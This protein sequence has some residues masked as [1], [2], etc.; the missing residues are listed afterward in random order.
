M[1][2]IVQ[3]TSKA[4]TGSNVT[5]SLTNP[6]TDG[7]TV[8]IFVHLATAAPD[9]TPAGWTE[10]G[11]ATAGGSTLT[12]YAKTVT[13]TGDGTF[14]LTFSTSS[15]YQAGFCEYAGLVEGPSVLNVQPS[16]TAS[17]STQASGAVTVSNIG[18]VLV[19][20]TANATVAYTGGWAGATEIG[21]PI[22]GDLATWASTF[23][24][25]TGSYN[26]TATL[27]AS[28]A[29]EPLGL[30][31]VLDAP[32][33]AATSVSTA[34]ATPATV[35]ISKATS[36]SASTATGAPTV[37]VLGE[38]TG[39]ADSASV[40]FAFPNLILETSAAA[41]SASSAVGSP[42]NPGEQLPPPPE[43]T[44]ADI[45]LQLY[46]ALG[47]IPGL[48]VGD[49]YLG[50]P[51]LCFLDGIGQIIQRIAD[52]A[53]DTAGGPGWSSLLDPTRCPPY[54]LAWLAQCVGVTFNQTQST[55]AAQ[56]AA[57]QAEQ[58]FNR[59]TVAALQN[60]AGQWMQPG[61]QV[62][63]YERDPDPYSFTVVLQLGTLAPATYGQTSAEYPTYAE[64]TAARSTYS[65]PSYP[66]AQ[67]QAAL[68]S[69]K[70]AGL[71][72]NIQIVAGPTYGQVGDAYSTYAARL[73]ALP[74]YADVAVFEP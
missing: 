60:A 8:L 13:G 33:E 16:T 48:G 34:T 19:A 71:L 39:A 64:R 63:I 3:H 15:V 7:N 42:Y 22:G 45:T 41:T 12:A 52:L 14:N 4:E 40:A 65:T 49:D 55:A 62:V 32:Y 36:H 44:V 61:Q 9:T 6:V 38:S 27:A 24:A 28:G 21:S 56:L 2:G 70:P 69:Q 51:L 57:I 26:P 73:A 29:H 31:V 58:G 5:V 1:S 46:D 68:E 25:A 72:M 17:G 67:V 35:I 47:P 50:W 20:I 11:Q 30:T 53:Q 59:G 74:T 54:A 18:A 37:Y 43:P 23:L 66:Q 10:L